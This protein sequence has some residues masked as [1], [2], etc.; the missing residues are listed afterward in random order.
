[1]FQCIFG[2][3]EPTKPLVVCVIHIMYVQL[4]QKPSLAQQQIAQNQHALIKPP[5]KGRP[6][7]QPS[8]VGEQSTRQLLAGLPHRC[9]SHKLS[10]PEFIWVVLSDW[11]FL[12]VSQ[13]L[14]CCCQLSCGVGRAAMRCNA[15][16]VPFPS[17][18]CLCLW[19]CGSASQVH[20]LVAAEQQL[21]FSSQV[22]LQRDNPAK[23]GHTPSRSHWHWGS[24]GILVAGGKQAALRS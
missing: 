4:Q 2:G 20:R 24:N 14:L 3:G 13:P 12:L 17:C 6:R 7:L 18:H 15:D 5:E 11:G 8:K 22:L 21:N 19:P 1:M 9:E 16:A 10:C 23:H